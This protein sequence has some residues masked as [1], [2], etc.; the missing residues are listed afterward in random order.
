MHTLAAEF[1]DTPRHLTRSLVGERQSEDRIGRHSPLNQVGD[2][3]GNDPRL[4]GSRTRNL[5]G[6]ARAQARHVV[7]DL[8][9]A[10]LQ[11]HVHA[12]VREHLG[13][14][15]WECILCPSVLQSTQLKQNANI[16]KFILLEVHKLRL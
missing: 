8:Q 7:V 6:A 2:P 10:H 4:A 14:Q 16:S 1:M 9:Q 15:Q 13:A 3:P 5:D 12:L 11:A